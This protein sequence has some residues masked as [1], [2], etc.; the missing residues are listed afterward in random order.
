MASKNYKGALEIVT[1][2]INNHRSIH[3][4]GVYRPPIA[5][6][7]KRARIYDLLG[8]KGK[9]AAERDLIAKLK[10][11]DAKTL[12]DHAAAK[13][14]SKAHSVKNENR[15][16]LQFLRDALCAMRYAFVTHLKSKKLTPIFIGN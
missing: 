14:K 4:Y 8:D 5:H 11:Q 6:Y 7:E 3:R 10:A 1:H 16:F 2:V 12:A 9:A 15:P 13:A